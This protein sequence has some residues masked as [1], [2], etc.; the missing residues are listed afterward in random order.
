MSDHP[1]MQTHRHPGW[2]LFIIC[3]A[4]LMVVLDATVMNVALPSIEKDLGFTKAG[5]TW[6]I[7]AYS[8]TF[9]GLLLFGGRTGDLYGRRKMFTIGIAIFGV[10]S[11]AGGLAQ[12]EAWLIIARA[13]QGIGGAIAAPTA[14]ALIATTFKEGEERN[15]A[16]GLYA[17]M[18]ASGAAVGLLLGGILTDLASWPWALYINVPIA[19]MVVIVAP[20]VL[21]DSKGSGSK[22][23]VPGAVTVT[24]GMVS[25]VYGLTNAA[26]H[27]WGD[28]E[29]IVA[30]VA[31]AVL[32]VSFVII[33]LRTAAPLLPFRILKNPART[34]AYLTMF[35]LASALFATFFFTSQYFQDVKGWSPMKTGVAFLPMPITIMFMSMVVVRRVV[36]KVG[37]RPLVVTGPALVILA[38]FLLG[39][40]DASTSYLGVLAAIMPL[41][42][43]MGC[44]F[45]PLT[46]TAVAGVA[47][48]ETGLASALL[49]TGQ[50]LGGAVGLAILG[51]IAAHSAENRAETL[52]ESGKRFASPEGFGQDVFVHGMN[53]AFHGGIVFPILAF[54]AAVV[55]IRTVKPAGGPP[56][57]G[58]PT[59]EPVIVEG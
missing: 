41:A 21:G 39:T 16:F 26:T 12:N 49:N 13:V 46:M 30:F 58:A 33:E 37:T 55:L 38:M 50:Q 23:D 31:A 47:P 15:R 27:S 51:T 11:L 14:L 5:L 4:Q 45:V 53:S 54:V 18:A 32:L 9:G 35:F 42:F 3:I 2:A 8:L 43:G 17:A 20:R 44:M 28:T 56:P 40:I 25:L 7:T 22:L 1:P 52:Q 19:I 36:A 48:H 24:G 59:H 57:A 34:G 29:T 6:V 10:A